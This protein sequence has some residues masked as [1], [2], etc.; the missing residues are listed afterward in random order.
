MPPVSIIIATYNRAHE[1]EITLRGLEKLEHAPGDDFEIMVIDNKSTDTTRSV[2]ERFAGRF[3]R[4]FRYIREERQG[5]SYARN[6]AVK[7][8][9]YGVVAFLDDDVD[10]DPGW[11]RNLA[12]A[13]EQGDYAVVGGKAYLIFPRPRPRW[14]GERD[15]GYLTKVDLGP[16][17]RPAGP[18]ELFGVN[19]SFKKEWIERV[20]GFRVDLGRM[21]TCLLS[22]EEGELLERLV[23]AGG[24]LLYE[25]GAVVGH[26]VPT[27]RLLR[28]WFWMRAYWGGLGAVRAAPG[29]KISLYGFVRVT[30]HVALACRGLARASVFHDPRGEEFFHRCLILA[31]RLGSWVGFA[32]RLI[33]QR[34]LG[35]RS[36]PVGGHT[37]PLPPQ[38]LSPLSPVISESSGACGHEAGRQPTTRRDR[39]PENAR[40]VPA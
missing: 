22:S 6:R 11:L 5:L 19:L 18:D 1:L 39:T 36:S 29:R 13:Y 24:K 7:E 21:G 2:A 20:G 12:A 4:G 10:V 25:P 33:T 32:G 9:R 31:A 37:G 14:L 38:S 40:G 34:D 28:R 26:R 27:V 35:E 23:S 17:R 30:W 16:D 15:E 8:A 3:G